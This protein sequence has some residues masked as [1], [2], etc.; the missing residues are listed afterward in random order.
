MADF[1]EMILENY[2]RQVRQLEREIKQLQQN[3]QQKRR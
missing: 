3:S 2:A 1:A